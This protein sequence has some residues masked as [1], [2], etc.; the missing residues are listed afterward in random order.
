MSGSLCLWR[1][2]SSFNQSVTTCTCEQCSKR[3]PELHYLT[4]VYQVQDGK[5]N[6]CSTFE[7]SRQ[8]HAGYE[9]MLSTFQ[10]QAPTL[11]TP[12]AVPSEAPV[13]PEAKVDVPKEPFKDL[14][15]PLT[16]GEDPNVE[17]VDSPSDKVGPLPAQ[18]Q[19]HVRDPVSVAPLD[20]PETIRNAK[21][22]TRGTSPTTAPTTT[23]TSTFSTP[24]SHTRR[25][26]TPAHREFDPVTMA[27]PPPPPAEGTGHN[28]RKS[29]S[30]AKG[31][32]KSTSVATTPTPASKSVFEHP[33]RERG[34]SQSSGWNSAKDALPPV[35]PKD[36]SKH[37][38]K[39]VDVVNAATAN[40][41][42]LE[43][44]PNP[45][46]I[47]AEPAEMLK[48]AMTI[49]NEDNR[50]RPQRLVGACET[51][52]A[53]LAHHTF[54]PQPEPGTGAQNAAF[55]HWKRRLEM[56]G[57]EGEV[58]LR[59]NTPELDELVSNLQTQ[60]AAARDPTAVYSLY[61][62]FQMLLTQ[63]GSEIDKSLV[64]M[65]PLLVRTL[66]DRPYPPLIKALI[67]NTSRV[68]VLRFLFVLAKDKLWK[69]K[70]TAG[71]CMKMSI[72][73]L[74][75]S[76][77]HPLC[78]GE[79][80]D[81]AVRLMSDNA[82]NCRSTGERMMYAMAKIVE[83]NKELTKTLNDSIAV[84]MSGPRDLLT[85]AWKKGS[86]IAKQEA[87]LK[88]QQDP[89]PA[90]TFEELK[91]GIIDEAAPANASTANVSTEKT[92]LEQE[93]PQKA[94]LTDAQQA[95]NALEDLLTG[96]GSDD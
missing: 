94:P 34:R 58:V 75:P 76:A 72:E 92:E 49:L 56:I 96:N 8:D 6:E 36:D 24:P 35:T 69:V 38:P 95:T 88:A 82:E 62:A 67:E 60:L 31:V 18:V 64:M 78:L 25:K 22:K 51:I 55:E 33:T 23:P 91:K 28:R 52:R 15:S 79:I 84:T 46:A 80:L 50:T 71:Q 43:Y 1:A 9:A 14:L 89:K 17:P 32:M 44:T 21:S 54:V 13:K 41:E 74:G 85:S 45:T 59:P 12:E 20:L 16:V 4:V 30:T 93:S 11:P 73:Q 26:S 77:L 53:V 86:A 47:L 7:F 19:T 42:L 66:A 40:K 39:M 37:E 65:V 87:K 27:A 90:Y 5:V 48:S 61:G 3:T 68:R 70:M 2:H 83:G 57:T 10:M 81:S 29:G 63:L